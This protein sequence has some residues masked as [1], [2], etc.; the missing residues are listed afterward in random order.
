MKV[1]WWESPFLRKEINKK[2]ELG[3]GQAWTDRQKYRQTKVVVKLLLQLKILEWSPKIWKLV[4]SS[5]I[6]FSALVTWWDNMLYLK[7]TYSIDDEHAQFTVNMLNLWQQC[8]IYDKL[9]HFM[10]IMLNLWRTCS[11]YFEHAPSMVNVLNLWW[12]CWIYS[13][14]TQFMVI[15]LNL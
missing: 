2:G 10:V 8:S 13:E 1:D 6:L 14:H 12:T 7:W 15:K 3:F 9:D 5:E 4:H 11:I